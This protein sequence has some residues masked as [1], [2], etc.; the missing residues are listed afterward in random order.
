MQPDTMRRRINVSNRYDLKKRPFKSTG[1]PE[2]RPTAYSLDAA[3]KRFE[4]SINFV[5]QIK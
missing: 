1:L 3:C 2:N 4:W 5:T